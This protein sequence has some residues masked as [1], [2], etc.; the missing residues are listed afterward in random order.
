[1]PQIIYVG[2]H[3]LT[4]SVVKHAHS[5][6]ELIYCT[7]G[8]GQL[9]YKNETLPYQSGDIIIIPPFFPHTNESETGFTNIHINLQSSLLTFDQP[10]LLHDD[11]N[12]FLLDAFRAAF[13]HFSQSPGKVTPLLS[14]YANLLVYQIL[15]RLNS[16]S[17]TPLIQEIMNHIIANYP[18][19]TFEL[20]TYLR[21]LPFNYDYLRK[22]FKKEVG[23]TPHQF[24]IN[25]RLQAAAE[26]LSQEEPALTSISEIAHTCGFHEPLYFSRVF[27]NKYGMSPAHY[28]ESNYVAPPILDN[29]SVKIRPNE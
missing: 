8:S 11:S 24:L 20:D 13:H 10:F 7:T 21:S 26:R 17:L 5:S 3:L 14:A 1:M 6:W 22:L 9:S 4:Y 28:Q 23:V 12:H 15:D 16:S 27:R 29:D 25:I 2:K 18:N 19:E